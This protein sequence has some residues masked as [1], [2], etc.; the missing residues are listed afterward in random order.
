MVSD[1]DFTLSWITDNNLNELFKEYCNNGDTL[2]EN[3]QDTILNGYCNYS[4]NYKK[5]LKTYIPLIGGDD[6]LAEYKKKYEDDDF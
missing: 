1:K 4:D 5:K 6:A 3:I 2:F